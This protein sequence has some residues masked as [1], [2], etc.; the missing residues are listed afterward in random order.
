MR[1]H[2][3][4]PKVKCLWWVGVGQKGSGSRS[5]ALILPEAIQSGLWAFCDVC[6][7]T[8]P[9]ALFIL[10]WRLCFNPLH[11]ISRILFPSRR[12]VIVS[13][14]IVFSSSVASIGAII[15]VTD[16]TKAP[17]TPSTKSHYNSCY[18]DISLWKNISCW[19]SGT[20][21]SRLLASLSLAIEGSVT[22]VTL[23]PKWLQNPPSI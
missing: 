23:I 8:A 6:C 15:W 14:P 20:A 5:S 12:F 13:A 2:L 17:V 10:V 21:K 19:S 18:S 4:T 3:G 11:S 22:L 16:V 9:A 1:S 7:L